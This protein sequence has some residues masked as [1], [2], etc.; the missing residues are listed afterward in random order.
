M[1]IRFEPHRLPRI[2]PDWQD[3]GIAVALVAAV[4]LL[5]L[6]ID[7]V[8]RNIERGQLLRQAQ[9]ADAMARA[10]NDQ[11]T[12]SA[13]AAWAQVDTALVSPT[14]ASMRTN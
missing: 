2:R 6:F 12:T 14:G 9:R 4:V 1:K 10:T 13:R 8:D 5:N 3:L 7:A 11:R